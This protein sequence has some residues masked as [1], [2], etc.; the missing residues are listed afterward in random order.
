MAPILFLSSGGLAL[1]CAGAFLLMRAHRGPADLIV[2]ALA[3]LAVQI[4]AGW[5]VLRPARGSPGGWDTAFA[6]RMLRRAAMTSKVFMM[7][8]SFIE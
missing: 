8:F 1:Q 3:V 2:L 7:A 6:R 4:A 5:T